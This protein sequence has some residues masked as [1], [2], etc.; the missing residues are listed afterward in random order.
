MNASFF[1]AAALAG[2]VAA[3][4]AGA[5]PY[6]AVYDAVITGGSDVDGLFG[7]AGRDLTGLNLRADITYLTT[8]PGSRSP[9]ADSD[10]VSGGLAFGTDPVIS[11]A[12]FTVGASSVAFSPNFYGDVYTSATFLDAYG[13]DELG[14]SFQT[15]ILPNLAGPVSLEQPFFSGGQGDASGP[16][17]QFS[18]ASLGNDLIDFDAVD[19]TVSG[20]PEPAAWSIMVAGLGVVGASLRRRRSS[21]TRVRFA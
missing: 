8:V 12:I 17:G 13:Y 15:Y 6:H 18:Y 2:L 5:A 3:A 1:C 19:V 20:V 21:S 11:S 7:S 9:M 4:P 14:N 10:E 16:I